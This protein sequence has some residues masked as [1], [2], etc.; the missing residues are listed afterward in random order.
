[1]NKEFT[2]EQSK[3]RINKFIDLALKD[4]SEDDE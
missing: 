2:K 3:E 1:M 4:V